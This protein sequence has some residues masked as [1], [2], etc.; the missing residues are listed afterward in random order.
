M[1]EEIKDK[2]NIIS[3]VD[4]LVL[5]IERSMTEIGQGMSKRK[6]AELFE[7]QDRLMDS[8]IEKSEKIL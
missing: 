1:K 8:L 6:R 7:Y 5:K 3:A 4:F 2:H